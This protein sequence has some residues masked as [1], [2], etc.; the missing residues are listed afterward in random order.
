MKN[1]RVTIFGISLDDKQNTTKENYWLFEVC[2]VDVQKDSFS[3]E[4]KQLL[5]NK[6]EEKYFITRS[7]Y[8]ESNIDKPNF[9]NTITI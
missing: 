3:N 5:I 6:I 8:P 7:Y 9:I 2:L 1:N 4:E